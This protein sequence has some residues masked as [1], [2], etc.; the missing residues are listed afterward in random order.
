MTT[1]QSFDTAIDELLLSR[2]LA[3]T[4]IAAGVFDGCGNGSHRHKIRTEKLHPIKQQSIEGDRPWLSAF[5]ATSS[6][7]RNF[8][9]DTEAVIRRDCEVSWKFRHAHGLFITS[10][11]APHIP[12]SGPPLISIFEQGVE[13]QQELIVER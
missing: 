7:T 10:S 5:P 1:G 13:K 2:D 6:S 8:A 12:I 4:D 3:F 9:F 11:H